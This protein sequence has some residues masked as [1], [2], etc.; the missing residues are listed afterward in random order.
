MWLRR[1]AEA[2]GHRVL[3]AKVARLLAVF[4]NGPT[5]SGIVLSGIVLISVERKNIAQSPY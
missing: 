2:P 4:V 1:L 5:N 3:A